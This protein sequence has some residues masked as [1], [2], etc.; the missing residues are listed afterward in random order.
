MTETLLL[1][2]GIYWLLGGLRML[3]D[4]KSAE[5][6][7]NQFEESD[8]LLFFMGVIVLVAGLALVQ[9]HNIWSGWPEILITIVI[10]AM[11]IEG[12][13]MIV[14]PKLLI[15]FARKFILNLAVVRGF[16]LVVMALGAAVLFL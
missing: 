5:R 16:G 13:M 8:A 6:I 7:F 11:I 15:G 1:I 14:M 9:F 2:I 4:A 3:I 10:W 12:A